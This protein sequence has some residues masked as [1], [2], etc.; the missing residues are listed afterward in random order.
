MCR[1]GAR[2]AP[3]DSRRKA[4]DCGSTPTVGSSSSTRSGSVSRPIA[5]LRRRFRPPESSPARR[6]STPSRRGEGAAPRGGP[7]G[8]APPRGPGPPQ[9]GEV[10]GAGGDRG[11]GE[12]IAAADH[13]CGGERELAPAIADLD[14]AGGER[15]EGA[16]AGHGGELLQE[17]GV[18]EAEAAAAGADLF[19]HPYDMADVERGRRI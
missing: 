11:R 17:R 12:R 10:P 1:A 2:I 8:G 4:R 14:Q 18:E 6:A 7:R 13:A 19:L 3:I 15:I 9:K 5:R 16:V